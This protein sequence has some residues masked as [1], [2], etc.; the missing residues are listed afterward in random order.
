MAFI[1]HATATPDLP[2][3]TKRQA[4]Y[5]YAG[6]V[7]PQPKQKEH[8]TVNSVLNP[9]PYILKPTEFSSREGK[10]RHVLRHFSL[11]PLLRD[12]RFVHP[13]FRFYFLL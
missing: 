13:F 12:F 10:Q 8:S 7:S 6:Q 3:L 2:S 1:V 9:L 4:C 5:S 11:S